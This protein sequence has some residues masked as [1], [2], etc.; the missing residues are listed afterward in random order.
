M[1]TFRLLP[2]GPAKIDGRVIRPGQT[3]KHDAD[4]TKL[5]KNRFELVSGTPGVPAEEGGDDPVPVETGFTPHDVPT[6]RRSAATAAFQ[7]K[8]PAPPTAEEEAPVTRPANA[9]RGGTS[10][11]GGGEVADEEPVNDGEEAPDEEAP[12]PRATRTTR[13]ASK[14]AA[15]RTASRTSTTRKRG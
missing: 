12:A 10:D 1:A 8:E 6:T 7:P 11:E 14:P 5:F 13:A 4:L 9:P 15:A 3:V 2:G